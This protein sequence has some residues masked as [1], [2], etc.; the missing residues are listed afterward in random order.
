VDRPRTIRRTSR[1]A[2]SRTTR[3]SPK[4]T[5]ARG[6]IP[7]HLEP[8]TSPAMAF[9]GGRPD[10]MRC[11]RRHLAWSPPSTAPSRSWPKAVFLHADCVAAACRKTGTGVLSAPV[12][13]ELGGARGAG[14]LALKRSACA[15]IASRSSPPLPVTGISRA[16]RARRA[17]SATGSYRAVNYSRGYGDFVHITCLAAARSMW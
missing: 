13:G 3:G 14:G 11:R 12:Y 16:W 5:C 6:D 1:C 17:G 10:S 7:R 2:P 15:R 9:Y 8:A 4:R